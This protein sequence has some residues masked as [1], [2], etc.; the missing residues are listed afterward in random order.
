MTFRKIM[1]GSMAGFLVFGILF[2]GLS[3][4]TEADT[5]LFDDFNDDSGALAGETANTLQVW[6]APNAT[7][8]TSELET[9]VPYGQ[10]GTV[11]AGAT[12]ADCCAGNFIPIGQDLTRQN[13]ID[14]G[15][16]TYT[17][18]VDMNKNTA[19]EIGLELLNGN[20]TVSFV[21]WNNKLNLGGNSD[22]WEIGALT[23]PRYG[24]QLRAELTIEVD[25]AGDSMATYS[26]TLITDPEGNPW[27][28]SDSVV[29]VSSDDFAFDGLQFFLV[30]GNGMDISGGFDNLSVEQTVIPE[31]GML[32]LLGI[33]LSAL[34]WCRFRRR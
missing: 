1:T 13:L 22:I 17:F 32:T 15:G 23:T 16:G 3:A 5:I 8:L 11:G 33:G 19:V 4:A 10:G 31:P 24:G 27:S 9:G 21:W 28:G 14:A 30:E 25:A 18:G 2:F 6:E 29:G 12:I 7:W 26:Y 34:P 20:D